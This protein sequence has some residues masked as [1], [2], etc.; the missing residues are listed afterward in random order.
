[1]KKN[2]NRG[3]ENSMEFSVYQSPDFEVVEI[4]TEKGFTISGEDFEQDDYEW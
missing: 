4:A 3:A 1:M 2:F